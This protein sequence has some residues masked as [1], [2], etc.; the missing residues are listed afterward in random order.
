M[1][2]WAHRLRLISKTP[3]RKVA[4]MKQH[5]FWAIA[6]TICMVMALYTGYKHK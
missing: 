3:R 1:L 2:K 5:K 4:P 6:A